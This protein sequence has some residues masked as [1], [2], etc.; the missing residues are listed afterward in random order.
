MRYRR[1]AEVRCRRGRAGDRERELRN[2][3]D[4]NV[5]NR[6]GDRGRAMV[7]ELADLDQ[8]GPVVLAAWLAKEELRHLLALAGAGADRH[9]ISHRLHRF[10]SV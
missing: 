6:D 4:A 1:T 7:A 9:C 8:I 10:Y 3:L 5:E 2:K